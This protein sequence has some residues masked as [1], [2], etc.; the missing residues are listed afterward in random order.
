MNIHHGSWRMTPDSIKNV[1][2]RH[3]R[4][5]EITLTACQ[6]VG[7]GALVLVMLFQRSLGSRFLLVPI[8][9]FSMHFHLQSQHFQHCLLIS[10]PWQRNNKVNRIF[11]L[12][13]SK[14]RRNYNTACGNNPLIRRPVTIHDHS[15]EFWAFC[16]KVSFIF[17]IWSGQT[18][19][20]ENEQK[21]HIGKRVLSQQ[22]LNA[23]MP[24][25]SVAELLDQK[26]H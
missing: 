11:L 20:M 16:E 3:P 12:F 24:V 4:V 25:V 19:K 10:D 21:E 14:L 6:S 22:M 23:M 15:E 2:L 9:D 5:T 26:A 18:F 13:K 8:K 7:C 17:L 1:L